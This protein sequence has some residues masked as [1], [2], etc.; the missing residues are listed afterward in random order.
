[1]VVQQLSFPPAFGEF[2]VNAGFH[3]DPVPDLPANSGHFANFSI[4]GAE[5]I[6][7]ASYPSVSQ[8]GAR[9]NAWT[10][11]SFCTS[12]HTTQNRC[13]K[14]RS[15]F[16]DPG[17]EN[18]EQHY[19]YKQVKSRNS[20]CPHLFATCA[21][22]AASQDFRR[23][24]LCWSFQSS[25]PATSIFAPLRRLKPICGA[26]LQPHLHVCCTEEQVQGGPS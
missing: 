26:L 11:L 5:Q 12:S 24:F 13:F 9:L 19:D 14:E 16:Q 23:H 17:F 8:E 10:Q 20:I 6:D 22:S 7:W 2:R 3:I 4:N 15:S 25:G 18:A 21:K 1:M